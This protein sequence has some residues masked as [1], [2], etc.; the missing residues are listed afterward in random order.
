MFTV[1]WQS[2]KNYWSGA[3][4]WM[5]ELEHFANEFGALKWT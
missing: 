2:K 4:P 3:Q 5:V 1:V